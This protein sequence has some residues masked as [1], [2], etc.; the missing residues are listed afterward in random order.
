[1]LVQTKQNLSVRPNSAL[2]VFVFDLNMDFMASHTD[3]IHGY[4]LIV[5][6]C[7][8]EWLRPHD[9]LSLSFVFVLAWHEVELIAGETM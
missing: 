1:M 2:D 6:H 9:I 3:I 5:V 7:L 8:Y 4:V